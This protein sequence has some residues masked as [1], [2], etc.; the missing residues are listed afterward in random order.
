MYESKA[1]RRRTLTHGSQVTSESNHSILNSR[2][3]RFP[4]WVASVGE[5]GADLFLA[6]VLSSD[7]GSVFGRARMVEG[8]DT[9]DVDFVQLVA[10]G[11]S[12]KGTETANLLVEEI[13]T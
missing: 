10:V 13:W 9:L 4:F 8:N 1:A 11:E 7:F 2:F 12:T 5:H 6:E 3:P